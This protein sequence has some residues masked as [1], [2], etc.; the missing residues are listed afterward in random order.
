M[1]TLAPPLP[2]KLKDSG[3]KDGKDLLNCRFGDDGAGGDTSQAAFPL[4]R[5]RTGIWFLL[6]PIVMLFSAFT[7][8]Y[9]VRQGL[10]DDWRPI[11]LSP[12]LWWNSAVLLASSITM[13]A[14]RRKTRL[15]PDSRWHSATA[16]LQLFP[17]VPVLKKW[18]LITLSLG[19]LF[20][21]GQVVAWRQL[22]ADGMYLATN[23]SS[24]FFYLLTAT[25]GLHLLGGIVGLAL[26][27]VTTRK[28]LTPAGRTAVG[29]ATIY[30][31]FMDALW[32]YIFVLLMIAP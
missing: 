13:E 20:L 7:S 26:V 15:A 12:L 31:H 23:P 29:V 11:A 17:Q 32:I 10:G 9:I 18:L 22:A 1:A 4:Q 16:K 8:A 27:T 6:V 2:R 21:I 28:R 19:A 25:H 5:Y 14:A 30:W 3:R 24:S